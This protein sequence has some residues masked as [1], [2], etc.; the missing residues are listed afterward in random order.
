MPF[1]TNDFLKID[2]K[3]GVVVKLHCMI[4]N[5][6]ENQLYLSYFHDKKI[7]KNV[8]NKYH[9]YDF[10][11]TQSKF[12]LNT[13]N[14]IDE[15]LM[16]EDQHEGNTLLE[17]LVLNCVPIP[18]SKRDSD[19]RVLVYEYDDENI[20]IN[21]ERLFVGVAY[22]IMGRIEIHSWF[23]IKDFSRNYYPIIGLKDLN[24]YNIYKQSSSI[25]IENSENLLS[26]LYSIQKEKLKFNFKETRNKLKSFLSEIFGGDELLSEYIIIY[27]TSRVFS[28]FATYVTGKF[29]LNISRVKLEKDLQILDINP[30]KNFNINNIQSGISKLFEQICGKF[31]YFPFN[32]KN[33][34]D[35]NFKSIFDVNKDELR[36][37]LLQLVDNTYLVVDERQMETGQLNETGVNNLTALTN[38]IDG[39]FM[40]YEY[41]YN[42]VRENLFNRSKSIKM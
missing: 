10:K 18:G 26:N 3:S 30:S 42:K 1:L 34:N 23:N 17:R 15:N 36:Q 38:L 31:I 37:G 19:M 16:D 5:I 14:E 6:F 9:E 8:V 7:D 27:L 41:P 35:K 33:L 13:E 21:E 28:R 11:L 4:Q 40:H 12:I 24:M 20:K 39:Q 25:K 32:I 22:V 2:H 29:C